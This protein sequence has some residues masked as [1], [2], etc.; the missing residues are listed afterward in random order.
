MTLFGNFL[1]WC[2]E[3][4]VYRP[5]INQRQ[6]GKSVPPPVFKAVFF[7]L[8][9]K[10]NGTCSF[11][12]VNVFVDPRTDQSMSLSLFH[13][14]IKDLESQRY[15]GR[16]AFFN[17]SDSFVV[18][19]LEEYVKV[20]KSTLTGPNVLHVSTNGK[21][22]RAK[23]GVELVKA[24]VNRFTFNVYNDDLDKP[25]PSEIQ[26]FVQEVRE[27]K[28]R[29]DVWKNLTVEVEKRL[30]TEVL[31]N[32]TGDA[33]NKKDARS[34]EY[35]GFCL[36]PFTIV[37]VDPLGEVSLCCNDTFVKVRMGNVRDQDIFDIWK[38]EQFEHYRNQLLTTGRKELPLCET[39]DYY[40]VGARAGL[41]RT[42]VYRLTK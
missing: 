38:S 17:N 7:E 24:G 19:D 8:R 3:E 39:C 21:A 32:K 13:K 2:Q 33:P 31:D 42:V 23:K 15:T 28:G 30:E 9:T 4:F 26:Q 20:A 35:R 12:P 22:F 25:I 10:C 34:M 6:L 18:R 14:V 11:C 41:L 40:G 29:S 37:C 5:E 1:R 27:R 16:V 36:Q